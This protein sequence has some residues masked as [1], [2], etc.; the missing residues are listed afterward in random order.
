MLKLKGWGLR[1][2][3]E[4]E[5]DPL[6]GEY[7]KR[8]LEVEPTSLNGY[9]GFGQEIKVAGLGLV[10][11]SMFLHQREMVVRVGSAAWNLFEPGLQIAHRDGIF[12]CELS[13]LDASGKRTVFRYRRKDILLLIMDSAY[14]NLDFELANLPANLPGWAERDKAEFIKEWSARA[15]DQQGSGGPAG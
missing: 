6:S 14:D 11:C 9:V 4:F 13:M 15:V 10:L 2:W 1:P 12:R 3:M 8:R 5:I 7:L